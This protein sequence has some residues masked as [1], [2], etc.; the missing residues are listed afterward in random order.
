MARK[1]LIAALL[2]PFPFAA[3]PVAAVF[4]GHFG[5]SQPEQ[6]SYHAAAYDGTIDVP[7]PV[8]TH[9]SFTY[10]I[11][12]PSQAGCLDAPNASTEG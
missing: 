10:G 12:E 9:S 6:L 7:A 5:G 8:L 1:S 3:L 11:A 2:L 4:F